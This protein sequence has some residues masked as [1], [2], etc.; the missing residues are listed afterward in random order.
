MNCHDTQSL[1]HG[2]LDGELDLAGNLQCEQHLRE[3][4]AC[5]RMLAEQQMLQTELKADALYYRAPDNLRDRVRSAL[6]K[7]G[8]ARVARFPW[9]SVAAAACLLLF[10]GLGF[11]LGQLTFAPSAR[12]RLSQQVAFSHIRSLQVEHLVDVPSADQHTVKPW[13]NGKLDFSPPTPD[14]SKYDFFLKGGRLDYLN[15]RPV[16]AVVYHRREHIINLFVWPE[17]ANEEGVIRREARQGYHLI[18]WSRDGMQYWV[19]SDL[20]PGQLNEFAERLR[21]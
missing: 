20:D 13:F 16:A 19:V 1:L 12:E 8:G 17:S 14:L 3:C 6:K 21:E 10:L 4:P 2:Y 15:G 9:R 11:V 5:A 18:H 7:R